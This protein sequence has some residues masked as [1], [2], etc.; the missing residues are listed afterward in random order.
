MRRMI[1]GIFRREYRTPEELLER[2]FSIAEE[3]YENYKEYF[4]RE[5]DFQRLL[6]YYEEAINQ[7]NSIMEEIESFRE[8]Y[9][10]SVEERKGCCKAGLENEMSINIILINKFLNKAIPK[11]R[12]VSG[13]CFFVGHRGCKVF[14]RPYLCR[15]FFCRRLLEK[16]Q[17]K[18]YIRLTQAIAHEL[19]LLY[20]ACEY[21]KRN[22]EYLLGE[23]II[24]L[25]IAGYS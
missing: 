19:T 1:A 25:D 14:A 12:E 11:E 22:L 24:E 23:F 8:C 9:I 15:E 21:I 4:E 5:E 18:D 7:S 20:Q 6:S 17:E 16:F 13:R 3:L 10:C 2:K